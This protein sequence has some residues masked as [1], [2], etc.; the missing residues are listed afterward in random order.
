M[1]FPVGIAAVLKRVN[2]V[3]QEQN[4]VPGLANWALSFLADVVFVA[5]NSTIDCFPNGKCVVCGNPVRLSLRK[6]VSKAVAREQFFPKSGETEEEVDKAAKVLL[7]LGGSLGANAINIALLNLYYQMLLE[8]EDLFIIWQTGVEAYNEMESLV[9][10]HP[11]LLL[12]PFM[13]KMDLA[14]AAADLIV[15]RAGA[16]TCYEILATGKPS[17]LIPSPNVAE[18]HQFKNASLMADLAGARVITEDE[19][20][21]TTLGN[22]IEEILGDESKMADMSERALKAANSNASVEIAQRILSLVNLSRANK[23]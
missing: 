14:Y 18:G 9:K 10:N 13:L 17:I 23:K 21:S 8:K 16:M 22:A 2:L 20:D 3:I 5:F 1:S 4:A 12:K 11:R 7:V 19:L 6:N 15:S